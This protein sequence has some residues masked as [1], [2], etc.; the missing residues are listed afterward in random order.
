MLVISSHR[1]VL[2][3]ALY[4]VTADECGIIVGVMKDML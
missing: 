2:E 3:K 4:S 1:L